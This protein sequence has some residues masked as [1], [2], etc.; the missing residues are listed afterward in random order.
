[1]EN[2]SNNKNISQRPSK[3]SNHVIPI[4]TQNPNNFSNSL[5]YEN[6][7]LSHNSNLSNAAKILQQSTPIK[8]EGN[9]SCNNN[10]TTTYSPAKTSIATISS[11]AANNTNTLISGGGGSQSTSRASG[12]NTT[13]QSNNGTLGSQRSQ[14]SQM[15]HM[16][17][18]SNMS[19]QISSFQYSTLN[20]NNQVSQ[21][22]QNN[23]L[24]NTTYQEPIQICPLP[25][26]APEEYRKATKILPFLWLGSLENSK[27]TNFIISAN[28]TRVINV[29]TFNDKND[30]ILSENYLQIPVLD[31]METKIEDFIPRVNSF[32]Y[33]SRR[34]Y[35][36]TCSFIEF[37]HTNTN[38]PEQQLG[39]QG[40]TLIH[41]QAGI[42]RACTFTI[43]FMMHYRNWLMD[44]A[45]EFVKIR[46]PF[47]SPNINFCGQLVAYENI[48]KANG[49]IKNSSQ[50]DLTRNRN[51]LSQNNCAN[52]INDNQQRRISPAGLV[53][54]S[55]QNQLLQ[56]NKT[57]TMQ[58]DPNIN[59]R[60]KGRKE[61]PK[62]LNIKNNVRKAL[63][64]GDKGSSISN[65]HQ[66]YQESVSLI[67]GKQYSERH[68]GLGH[69]GWGFEICSSCHFIFFAFVL[70]TF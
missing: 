69:T 33:E 43:A 46:R 35:E 8:R 58:T 65:D 22:N 24:Q 28:I 4:V 31:C 5:S 6:S 40:I 34:L 60:K 9:T 48:L 63:C 66:S 15:S 56:A 61:R 21:N 30:R 67:S 14:V 18:I 27:D 3:N 45:Y 20:S 25:D 49:H 29:S 36:D 52:A 44:Q 23:N 50:E 47:V 7:S 51:S 70:K 55:S 38:N 17:H 64:G 26:N 62:M 16:S 37:D 1:M 41:C 54:M 11:E 2:L 10:I 12:A 32:I 19:S 42:S 39:P 13:G 68:T 57:A 53:E 59:F